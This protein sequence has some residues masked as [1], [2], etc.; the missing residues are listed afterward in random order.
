M[1]HRQRKWRN[2]LVNPSFQLKYG[3]YFMAGGLCFLGLFVYFIFE[4]LNRLQLV[5]ARTRILDLSIYRELQEISWQIVL[6][7]SLGCISFMALS[8]MY[9]VFITH[10]IAGPMVAILAF[11]EELKQGNY[12]SRRHLRKHDELNPIMEKLHE[13]AAQWRNKSSHQNKTQPRE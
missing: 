9:A 1:G 5:M 11:I 4:Q 8:F 7:V 12:E 10:R 13:L 3:F 6:I 2:I